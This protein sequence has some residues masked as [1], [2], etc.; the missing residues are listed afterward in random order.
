MLTILI[1]IMVRAPINT[2]ITQLDEQVDCAGFS[3][4]C[5][6]TFGNT[7]KNHAIE[8]HLVRV[9]RMR[10]MAEHP[11]LLA[12]KIKRDIRKNVVVLVLRELIVGKL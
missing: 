5:S 6:L 8:I 3:S 12:K 2:A 10:T 7:I 11:H 4:S 1:E 9:S